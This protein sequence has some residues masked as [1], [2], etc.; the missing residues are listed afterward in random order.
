MF[1]PFRPIRLG[2]KNL[3]ALGFSMVILS[4]SLLLYFTGR[5]NFD[6]GTGGWVF[7]FGGT[8]LIVFLVGAWSLSISHALGMLK[9]LLEPPAVSNLSAPP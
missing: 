6:G 7:T 3:Q 5:G 8:A 9:G 2:T 1:G 4:G